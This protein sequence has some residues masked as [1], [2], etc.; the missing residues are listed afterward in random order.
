ME[1]ARG[2]EKDELT[3]RTRVEDLLGNRKLGIG[4]GNRAGVP[5]LRVVLSY[6]RSEVKAEERVMVRVG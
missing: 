3:R 1:E 6:P 2:N 5:I 4:Y